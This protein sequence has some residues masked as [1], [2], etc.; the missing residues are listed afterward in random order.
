PRGGRRCLTRGDA[1]QSQWQPGRAI[2]ERSVV[3][4]ATTGEVPG[5]RRGMFPDLA[6]AAGELVVALGKWRARADPQTLAKKNKQQ[7]GGDLLGAFEAKLA[8]A[9]SAWSCCHR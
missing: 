6:P 8:Q 1:L 2:G 3:Q 4:V 7:R 9:V 5:N